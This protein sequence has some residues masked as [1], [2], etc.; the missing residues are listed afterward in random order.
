VTGNPQELGEFFAALTA[1]TGVVE[2]K[3]VEEDE[4]EVEA[5]AS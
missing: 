4:A 1:T 2:V 3:A 5:E